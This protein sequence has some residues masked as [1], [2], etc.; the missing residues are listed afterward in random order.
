M[1]I[2]LMLTG[3]TTEKHIATGVETYS[4]RISKYTGFEMITLPDL[5]NTRNMPPEEQ[6][7][8]L[9]VRPPEIRQ[10]MGLTLGTVEKRPLAREIRTSARIV[11]DETR[12][13]HVTLKTEGWIESWKTP[14][15]G[16]Q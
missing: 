7:S 3:K 4:K 13:Y 15:V 12:L 16:Q 8:F 6:K 14:A 10:R 9:A 2:A 11:P 5:K 1:K